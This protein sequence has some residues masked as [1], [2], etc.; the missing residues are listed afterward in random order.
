M[1]AQTTLQPSAPINIVRTLPRLAPP[2]LNVHV[3]V[4]T[5]MSPHRNS[6][7]LSTGS[8]THLGF[9]VKLVDSSKV[10]SLSP[11][12][13]DGFKCGGQLSNAVQTRHQLLSS[14]LNENATACFR[15]PVRPFDFYCQV[16]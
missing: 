14:K 2:H 11:A 4:R 16:E 15:P 12:R 6:E 5:M 1:T 8:K 10:R 3:S 9:L 7:I 13:D